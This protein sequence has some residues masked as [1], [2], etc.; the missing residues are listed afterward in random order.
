MFKTSKKGYPL[1]YLSHLEM[2]RKGEHVSMTSRSRNGPD[3]MAVIWIHRDRRYFV[4]TSGATNPRTPIYRERW[5]SHNGR[6]R[7][8][9]ITVSI[10]KVCE[11]HYDTCSQIDGHNRCRQDDLGLEKKFEVKDWSTR[12]NTSLLAMCIVDAW[13][14]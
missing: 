11:T 14:L 1:Q 8:E 12:V 13:K 9:E 2:A 4:S 3:L 5:R 10:P 7:K 6:S